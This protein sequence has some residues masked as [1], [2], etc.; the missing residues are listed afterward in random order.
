M[1][2]EPGG[3]ARIEERLRRGKYFKKNIQPQ[4][5]ARQLDKV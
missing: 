2:P 4:K 3:K 1:Y 5:V